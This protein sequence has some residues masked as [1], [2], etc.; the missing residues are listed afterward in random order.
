MDLLETT[1][2]SAVPAANIPDHL[3][4]KLIRIAPA[5]LAKELS[6]CRGIADERPQYPRHLDAHEYVDENPCRSIQRCLGLLAI[7]GM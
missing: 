7:S 6:R 2:A 1:L 5:P 3:E 4:H